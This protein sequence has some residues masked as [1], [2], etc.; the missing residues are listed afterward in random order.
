M[1]QQAVRF[2]TMKLL[3]MKSQIIQSPPSIKKR[4]VYCTEV[5][6][7]SYDCVLVSKR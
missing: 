7:D 1:C 6:F 2:C 4:R 3:A 5:A